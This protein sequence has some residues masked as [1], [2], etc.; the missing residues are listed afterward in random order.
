MSSLGGCGHPCRRESPRSC[1]APGVPVREPGRGEARSSV[2][3]ASPSPPRPF[4]SSDPVHLGGR[5]SETVEVATWGGAAVGRSAGGPGRHGLC[6]ERPSSVLAF[7]PPSAG[8]ARGTEGAASAKRTPHPGSSPSARP[9]E[10][11]TSGAWHTGREGP[12][13]GRGVWYFRYCTLSFPL[14][15]LPS[16]LAGRPLFH[17]RRGPITGRLKEGIQDGRVS[18]RAVWSP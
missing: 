15:H 2:A 18:I 3:T 6:P 1:H 8:I 7:R 17:T 13:G 4:P 14:H 12:R 5:A 16:G 11:P 9:R 10:R